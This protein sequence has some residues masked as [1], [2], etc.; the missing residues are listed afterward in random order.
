VE[1]AKRLSSKLEKMYAAGGT[2]PRINE[3]ESELEQ[4]Y[5]QLESQA[6]EQDSETYDFAES[7]ETTEVD[8]MNAP[9]EA[10]LAAIDAYRDGRVDNE[11]QTL[12]QHIRSFIDSSGSLKIPENATDQ[13]IESAANDALQYRESL[14]NRIRSSAKFTNAVVAPPGIQFLPA[15]H[16]SPFDFD[17]FSIEKIGEGEGA[18]AYGWG[19]Y[20]AGLRQVGEGYQARLAKDIRVDGVIAPSENEVSQ[21]TQIKDALDI[22]VGI[23]KAKK[24]DTLPIEYNAMVNRA[25]R[26]LDNEQY[27]LEK[28]DPT[29]ILANNVLNWWFDHGSE[30]LK[31]D[32][33]IVWQ[34]LIRFICAVRHVTQA[35]GVA[36]VSLCNSP[37][38]NVSVAS[39]RSRIRLRFD[40]VTIMHNAGSLWCKR[41]KDSAY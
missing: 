27:N 37:R 6:Q 11:S 35:Q 9:T 20:F 13:Q 39:G 38:S 30:G 23:L 34:L 31:D 12:A 3:Y 7:P 33:K 40:S 15:F 28:N 26:M 5:Q 16:G 18:Q 25:I 36:S 8:T 14:K 21:N 24:S 29:Y 10:V 41:R 22:L 17:K 4:I 1:K 2:D 32:S 19:L